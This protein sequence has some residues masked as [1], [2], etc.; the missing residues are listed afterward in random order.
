MSFLKHVFRPDLNVQSEEAKV[1]YAR[2]EVA[3]TV[4]NF[5]AAILFLVGSALAFWP[6]TGTISTWMFIYGSIVFAIKPTLSAWREIKLYRM[7]DVT[8]LAKGI[9]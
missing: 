7:G 8:R 2:V 4:A 9:E 1:F 5:V 3:Y 6:S